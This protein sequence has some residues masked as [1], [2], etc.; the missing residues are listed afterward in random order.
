MMSNFGAISTAWLI[1]HRKRTNAHGQGS[2]K[3]A[4]NLCTTYLKVCK[5][6]NQKYLFSILPK[7][8]RK[9]CQNFI[10]G[11]KFFVRFFG[12]IEKKMI[13]FWNL[14]NLPTNHKFGWNNIWSRIPSFFFV[15]HTY[16]FIWYSFYLTFFFSIFFLSKPRRGIYATSRSISTYCGSEYRWAFYNICLDL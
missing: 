9:I 11:Q 1:K 10:L 15:L 3:D 6:R 5:F 16:F 7:N 2:L 8:E 4:C 12:R 14:P 13:C